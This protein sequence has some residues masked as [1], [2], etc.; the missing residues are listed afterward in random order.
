[1]TFS[2]TA[3]RWAARALSSILATAIVVLFIVHVVG[4]D[5][6]ARTGFS[7]AEVMMDIFS[8][9]ALIGYPMGWRNEKTG[10]W[11]IVT[12]VIGYYAASFVV[13]GALPG[14]WF[15]PLM[16]VP[17]VLYLISSR[18]ADRPDKSTSVTT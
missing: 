9:I 3:V 4:A 15:Y 11:M 18:A 1:M 14:G 16:I 8:F 13:T 10:G 2:E 6:E 7:V 17:G 12:G 5:E